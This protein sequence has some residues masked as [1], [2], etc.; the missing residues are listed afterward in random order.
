[1]TTRSFVLHEPPF[2]D[3]SGSGVVVAVVD[4]GIHAAHPH[5]G[6]PVRGISLGECRG[7]DQNDFVDRLGHGTAVAAAIRE[8]AP[9]VELLAVRVFDRVLATSASRLA[10]GIV[11]AVDHDARVINLSLGTPKPERGAMLREAVAYATAR[12]ALVVSAREVGEVPWLPGSLAGV[13]GVCLDPHCARDMIGARLTTEGF[14]VDA[15]GLPRPIPGVPPER[16]LSGV[17]FAVANVSGFLARLLSVRPDIA[18]P[19]D[20]ARA[21]FGDRAWPSHA[22]EHIPYSPR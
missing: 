6:G 15:S 2:V 21:C 11:W 12:R 14:V 5:V 13:V 19:E 9:R 20:V 4:S 22:P 16:N 8:K 3:G 18:S 10:R 7:E 17:S 1:M